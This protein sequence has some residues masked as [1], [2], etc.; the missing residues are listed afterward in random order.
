MADDPTISDRGHSRRPCQACGDPVGERSERLGRLQ[1]LGR[2]PA[3][4]EWR[5]CEECADE[6]FRGRLPRTS[7]RL[8][9]A[10]GGCPLERGDGD[11]PSPWEENVVRALEDG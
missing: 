8:F 4:G 6:K 3:K 1:L 2:T 5:Y 9:S 7:A 10:G 11:D